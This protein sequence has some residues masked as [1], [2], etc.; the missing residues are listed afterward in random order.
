MGLFFSKKI[1]NK[2]KSD[3]S[4]HDWDIRELKKRVYFLEQSYNSLLKEAGIDKLRKSLEL[5]VGE[6]T[7]E[8]LFEENHF[9][10]PL[11]RFDETNE[12]FVKRLGIKEQISEFDKEE[13]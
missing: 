8:V 4:D 6:D 13:D 7:E 1:I 3:I 2:L 9:N 11:R 12:E 5:L 10:L